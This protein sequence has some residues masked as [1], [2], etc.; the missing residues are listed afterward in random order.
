MPN[1]LERKKVLLVPLDPVHDIGLKM[2]R[3]GI[4]EAGHQTMLL[5]PDL[6]PEEI[7]SVIS[8]ESPDQ[9]L[10]SRTL[11]YGVAELLARFVDLTDAAGLRDKT[12]LVVGGMAIR[13]ELAAELGFDAGFGPGTSVDEVIAYIEGRPFQPDAAKVK[14]EKAQL[15]AGYTYEYRHPAIGKLLDKIVDGILEWTEGKTS[16]GIKRAR[17]R[18]EAWDVEM[19][20]QGKIDDRFSEAYAALCDPVAEAYYRKGEV[21]PKT[22]RQS[23]EEIA[24]L[25]DY[26]TSVEKRMT[27]RRLQ[28]QERQPRVFIQY[29]T[30][31]PF[32][33]IAHIKVCEAWGADGVVHF[34]PSWGA[35]TEGF[36]GDFLTHQEDGSVITPENLAWIKA[37]L[38]PSTLWQVRAHRGVNT[39][40]TVVLAGKLGA[41]LTKINIAYGALAAGTDPARLTV[42]GVEA[43]RMAVKYNLPFDVVTNEELAG[44]PAHKAFAGMLIV[45]ALARRLGGRPM[46]QPLFAFSPE[47]MVSGQMG[48]NYVDFNAAKIEAL[49]AII[50]APIWPGAPIGFL[51]QTEDRVQSSMTTALHAALAASLQVDAISIA[52]SDEAY[53]GGPIVA[54]SRVDTLRAVAEGF[55]FFGEG[56]VEPTK[57]AGPWAREIV[58]KIEA[59]LRAVADAPSFPEA[60]YTGLLGSK[61]EGAY[62]GRGGRGTV[63]TE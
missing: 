29:G 4:E 24:R 28:H 1:C 2:L 47:V 39:P 59:V 35:R 63:T 3:R 17:L 33:D 6:P 52:S 41:D 54:A 56:R 53:S 27:V 19:W 15:T 10:V 43:I 42:D 61:E 58:E 62:P 7:V 34:D 20:R 18:D 31:C 11:G 48:D 38:E 25:E 32:M 45:A 36:I 30:G 16:L 22:R 49:R 44:V 9:V 55:R 46:L 14:K 51:T 40:E 12:T 57:Q 26:L 8:R 13:P 37:A 21:H 60:L 50:D 5:P 23:K